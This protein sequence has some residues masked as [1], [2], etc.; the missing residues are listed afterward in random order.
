MTRRGGVARDLVWILGAALAVN[1]TVLVQL[2]GHPLLQPHGE[3][4]TT[5]YVELARRVAAGGPLAVREAFFVSPLL[6]GTSSPRSSSSASRS[7]RR[8]SS[9]SGWGR[10]RSGSST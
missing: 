7:S 4:D 1:T 8:A 10:R 9:I 3:L 2:G 6:P 5:Y